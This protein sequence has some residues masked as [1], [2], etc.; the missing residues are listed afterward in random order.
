MI[1]AIGLMSGTSCDGVD[2]SII[3]TDGVKKVEFIDNYYHPY[4]KKFRFRLKELKEKINQFSDIKKYRLDIDTLERE[5]T[6]IH[7]KTVELL[8]KKL[9]SENKKI[10]LVGF[11]GQTIFHS[12]KD[13]QSIQIGDGKLLSQLLNQNVVYNF[14]KKDI[15]NG[16]QG[17]PLTPVFHQL[18]KNYLDFDFPVAFINIGGIANIT[19]LN[20]QKILSFDTGPGNFL[21]D[22]IIQI[23]TKNEIQFDNNG[24]LAFKGTVDKNILET[25]LDDPFFSN[26]PPKSLDVND[27]N[28]SAIRTLKLEDAVATFSEFTVQSIIRSLN[29]LDPLPKK[30][31][32][33]GGGRKNKFIF[34]RLKKLV[35]KIEIQKIDKYKN[36][37]G[38]F[39]ESQA[40]AYL[41]VRTLKKI[42][43]TFPETTGVAEP[44][45]GGDLVLA[46]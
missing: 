27:F 46:K 18:L 28:I 9:G 43:I 2:A 14:R 37:D 45:V 1:T 42:P 34:E 22:S 36:I 40:F 21:I 26:S 39:I 24:D 11:H 38:D 19:Y 32:L 8:R 5:L 20:N 33:C 4:E 41:A 7:A 31:I 35:K 23:K 6:L 25:Y 10:E 16:G 44:L 30:I 13:K 17:A 3:K 12:F 15:S 29:F